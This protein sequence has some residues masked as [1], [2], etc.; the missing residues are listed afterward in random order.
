MGATK[1]LSDRPLETFGSRPFEAILLMQHSIS[2][3][4]RR[5]SDSARASSGLAGTKETAI[6]SPFHRKRDAAAMPR[7]F[8]ASH[9]NNASTKSL[10][11]KGCKSSM[12]S[13]TPMY[14]TGTASS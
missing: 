12:P 10:A 1:G 7:P 4:R 9:Q 2:H 8:H 5:S 14:H 3:T 6:I 13:P 11:T